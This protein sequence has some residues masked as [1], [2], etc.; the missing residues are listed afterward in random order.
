MSSGNQ[1]SWQQGWQL[2]R[3]GGGRNKR[4]WQVRKPGW[5]VQIPLFQLFQKHCVYGSSTPRFKVKCKII[6]WLPAM[7]G[8]ML[9]PIVK[10]FLSHLTWAIWGMFKRYFGFVV[11]LSYVMTLNLTC[12]SLSHLYLAGS[13]L[14]RANKLTV[15]ETSRSIVVI[16]KTALHHSGRAVRSQPS[17]L[18]RAVPGLNAFSW[19]L[20]LSK[21]QLIKTRQPSGFGTQFETPVMED[22]TTQCSHNLWSKDHFIFTMKITLQV[23]GLCW[24]SISSHLWAE[25]LTSFEG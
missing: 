22:S 21:E 16:I 13:K 19:A 18:I 10:S 15:P 5:W 14:H 3:M 9:L 7:N 23:M 6:Y 2:F 11:V 25:K 8:S 4:K 24:N 12:K 20:L 1:H 17:P